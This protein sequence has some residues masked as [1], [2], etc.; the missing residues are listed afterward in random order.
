MEKKRIYKY[1]LAS[2]LLLLLL[3]SGCDKPEPAAQ[4]NAELAH[5]LQRIT[6][7]LVFIPGGTFWMG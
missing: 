3:L 2:L 4:D 6:G 1:S 7:D 5:Y